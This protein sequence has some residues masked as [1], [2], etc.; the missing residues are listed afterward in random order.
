MSLTRPLLALSVL[1]LLAAGAPSPTTAAG[2]ASPV[3][4]WRTG[5]NHGLV[6]V[7]AC[8][9]A[10]CGRIL[11]SDEIKGD[12]TLKDV[13]NREPALRNRPLKGLVFMTGFAGGPPRWSGGALYRPSNG[14]TYHGSIELTD[15]NTLKLKGCIIAPL[16]A[17]Q[18]WT[19]VRAS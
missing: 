17:S 12:P 9:G 11:S 6:E 10:I 2:A 13:N 14:G 16:C 5:D 15:A 1:L 18:T 7:Y 3:G 8:G 4:L 19:R